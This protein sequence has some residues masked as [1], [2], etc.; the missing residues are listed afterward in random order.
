MQAFSPSW[1]RLTKGTLL[2]HTADYR[3]KSLSHAGLR[4]LSCHL[5]LSIDKLGR[6]MSPAKRW[7][8]EIR[9]SPRQQLRTTSAWLVCR[10]DSQDRIPLTEKIHV[11]THTKDVDEHPRSTGNECLSSH[12][13][14][15]IVLPFTLIRFPGLDRGESIG[16]MFED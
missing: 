4:I 9:L 13:S 15:Y 16:L 5:T 1:P 2:L 8:R 6:K 14:E 11:D 7:K 3:I 12:P 10:A